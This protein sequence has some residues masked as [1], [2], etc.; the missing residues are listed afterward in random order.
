LL[1]QNSFLFLFYDQGWYQENL[2]ESGT[3]RDTPF[4]VGAGMDFQTKA[5]IFSISYAVGKQFDNP[6]SVKDGKISFGLIN[7]F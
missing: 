4:G 2:A 5:G 6:I 3:V 7:N 1:E